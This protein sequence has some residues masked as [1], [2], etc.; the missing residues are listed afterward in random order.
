VQQPIVLFALAAPAVNTRV[1]IML[2]GFALGLVIAVVGEPRRPARQLW[3]ITEGFFTRC[4]SS[5][6]APRCRY[7]SWAHTLNSFCWE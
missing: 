6:R 7:A 1:S 2:A 4:S 5:G 3:G